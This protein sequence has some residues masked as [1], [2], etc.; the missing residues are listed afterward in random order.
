VELNSPDRSRHSHSLAFTLRSLLERFLVHVMLN[1]HWEPLTFQLPPIPEIPGA[2]RRCIDTALRSPE[3]IQVWDDA[4]A[5]V[6]ET[7]AVQPRSV[8]LLALALPER[9]RHNS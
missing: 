7:H 5:V 9:G 6:Q 3:D 4:P 2:W 1:A 8:V